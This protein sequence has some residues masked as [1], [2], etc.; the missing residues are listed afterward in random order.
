MGFQKKRQLITKPLREGGIRSTL[1][2]GNGV[3][4]KQKNISKGTNVEM[5]IEPYEQREKNLPIY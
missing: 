3:Y 1:E 5:G 2:R 4:L